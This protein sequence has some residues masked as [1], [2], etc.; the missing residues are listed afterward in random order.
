MNEELLERGG[1]YSSN[2]ISFPRQQ[3]NNLRDFKVKV[4]LTD[5]R[6]FKDKHRGLNSNFLGERQWKWLEKELDDKTVDVILLG[7]SIQI[8]PTQ[9]I[10]EETWSIFP[11]ERERLLRLISHSPCSNVILL[12]GDVHMAEISQVLFVCCCF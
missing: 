5:T 8:L 7:S 9:K 3:Q 10:V 2:I 11:N 6:Y 12:S 1:V 4:I